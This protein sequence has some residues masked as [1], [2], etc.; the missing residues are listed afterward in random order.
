[1]GHSGLDLL[2]LSFSHFNPKR[3]FGVVK[4][5]EDLASQS[6]LRTEW[7]GG[8]RFAKAADRLARGS[9]SLISAAPR[10]DL[11]ESQVLEA[12]C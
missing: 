2:R 4:W 10:A 9:D 6:D 8:L 1:M 5:P 12:C 11:S 3:T 7:G